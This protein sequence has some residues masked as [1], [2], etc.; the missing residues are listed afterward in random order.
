[1]GNTIL[2]HALFACGQVDLDLD[3]FF[4]ATGNSHIIGTLNF[5]Q[6]TA[7]HLL[8]YPNPDLACILQ[9]TCIG[10]WEVLRIKMSYSKWMLENPGLDNFSKFYSYKV[11]LVFQHLKLWQEF[12][13]AIRDPSW[14][15]CDHPDHIK[16]LPTY[17]QKEIN[18]SYTSP[19]FAKPNSSD[20]LVEWLSKTYYDSFLQE[21]SLIDKVHVLELGQYING[22]YEKL[23][24]V[25]QTYLGWD[26]DQGRSK[27]FHNKVL[28]V[29]SAYLNW[30]E[31]IKIAI[32]SIINN[33]AVNDT[34]DLW[35]QS[36][37]IA[38]TC[39]FLDQDPHTI[40]WNNIGC[41]ADENNLYLDKFTRTI[42]Y[43]KTI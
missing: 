23:I 32:T 3:K 16:F 5:S 4:S 2:A 29:N 24:N 26:W 41:N 12:Y 38:K 31:K 17:I 20:Q 11:D 22:E 27:I 43:G 15:E 9:I 8:E 19:N 36:L 39:Q 30:L 13:Q 35:E 7:T 40:N 25:C 42:H 37:I 6:L 28:E 1:M 21:S 34:F 18:Q 33:H 14:P 10:W